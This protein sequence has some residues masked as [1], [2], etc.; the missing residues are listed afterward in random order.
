MNLT[1]FGVWTSYRAIGEDNAGDAARL[2]QDLG[3][4]A[5]WLGGSPEPAALAPL[6]S[7]TDRLAAATGIVN[8][9]QS[10]PAVAAAQQAELAREFPDRSLIGIGVGHPEATSDYGHPLRAMREFLDGLDAAPTPLPADQ[11][12]LAALG[13]KMLDLCGERSLGTHSYF[14]PVEHTRFARERL[15]ADALIAVEL[16]VVLDTDA[17]RA[18]T[19]AR[20]YAKL[21]LGLRNYTNN[22]LRFGF[23][24]SDIAGEGSDRLIDTII[25]HGGADEIAAAAR[26]HLDAGADHVCLQTVGASGVPRDEWG[27]LAAALGLSGGR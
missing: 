1:R 4:G 3:F 20:G 25:P 23:A 26:A 12:A 2:A 11:R 17:E 5:F 8:V 10:E 18:R 6:L 9:W 15:G 21:Y 27:S 19:K 13:P 14:V 22:L 16:A 7:A 24:E